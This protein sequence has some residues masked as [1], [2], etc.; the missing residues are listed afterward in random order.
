M[1]ILRHSIRFFLLKIVI[2]NYYYKTQNFHVSFY[3]DINNDK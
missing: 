1:H 3:K 2:K